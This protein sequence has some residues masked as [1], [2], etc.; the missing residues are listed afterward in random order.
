VPSPA[1]GTYVLWYDLQYYTLGSGSTAPKGS[2]R[3]PEESRVEGLIKAAV[4]PNL[5][6][7]PSAAL[8]LL[9]VL[10]RELKLV[11]HNSVLTSISLLLKYQPSPL[12]RSS[13]RI[14]LVSTVK[15]SEL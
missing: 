13:R 8:L 12:S 15:P 6:G 9:S 7:G 2:S 3:G 11:A 1:A 5:G 4:P 14:Y 10:A